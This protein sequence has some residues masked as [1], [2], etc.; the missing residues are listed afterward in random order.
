MSQP[1]IET[2]L[3]HRTQG[4]IVAGGSAEVT[5]E[6]EA[7]PGSA[8][9]PRDNILDTIEGLFSNEVGIV[10][11]EGSDGIGKTTILRQ[12]RDRHPSHTFAVFLSAGS[13]WA[14]D[15]N[16]LRDE[17]CD[18]MARVV[19][20]S[21]RPD[22][23]SPI[24][25][26][27]SR[28]MYAVGRVARASGE[29]LYFILDGLE[30]IPAE[31]RGTRDELF[32]LMPFLMP[33]IRC[34][35]T[36]PSDDLPFTE[37]ARRRLK[38]LQIS[39]VTREEAEHFLGGLGLTPDVVRVICTETRG[40]PGWLASVRRLLTQGLSASTVLAELHQKSPDLF[41][42]EWQTV[43]SDNRRRLLLALL[44]RDSRPYS[45]ERLAQIAGV[46]VAAVRAH[47]GSLRFLVWDS[48]DHG[49]ETVRYL[50]ESFRRAADAELAAHRA[51]VDELI[52]AFLQREPE[53]E[54][55]LAQL[56]SFFS[57]TDR[58][59]EL[60]A[61][62]SPDR[63]LAL[64]RKSPSIAHVQQQTELGAAAARKLGRRGDIVRF[65]LQQ[66]TI[67]EIANS[68]L[69]TSEVR[70][71]TA[72]HDTD[73][74]LAIAERA[75][76]VADRFKLLVAVAR[77]RREVGLPED[78]TLRERILAVYGEL[79]PTSL[80]DQ[81][82]E[83]AAD[84]FH[85]FP[86]LAIELVSR[87]AGSVTSENAL[88][89]AFT[90]LA[91]QAQ[92]EERDDGR[93]KVRELRDRIGTPVAKRL[94]T[95]AIM[96]LGRL[97][98]AEA[99]AEAGRLD[100]TADQLYVLRH[101]MLANATRADAVDVLDHALQLALQATAY[102]SN[103]QV[104]RELATCLPHVPTE[105]MAHFYLA[106]FDAHRTALERLGPTEEF[107]RL[108]LLLARARWR[109]DRI[110][111][112]DRYLDV[113]NAIASVTDLA[114]R[115][116]CGARLI[117][118]LRQVDPDRTLDEGDQLHAL[119][120]QEFD[121]GLEK[122][123][124]S[125]ADHYEATKPVIEAL[126]VAC[127]DLGAR[128]ARRLNTQPRRDRAHE[129]LV[130]AG[131]SNA[132]STATADDVRQALA[133]IVD[134]NVR[135]AAKFS[136]LSNIARRAGWGGVQ[137]EALTSDVLGVG[138]LAA[139]ARLAAEFLGLLGDNGDADVRDQLRGGVRAAWDA[140]DRDWQK[141]DVGYDVIALVAKR[142]PSFARELGAEIN[143][144][145]AQLTLFDAET[146]V[147]ANLGLRLASRAYAGLVAR[148]VSSPRD[149]PRLRA[150]IERVGSLT[151]Q[152]GLWADTALRLC[153]HG[154]QAEAEA[155]LRD[156]LLP[157]VTASQQADPELRRQLLILV[158]PAV[159][160]AARGAFEGLLNELPDTDRDEALDAVTDALL[161][162]VPPGEP[163]KHVWGA[164]FA[165]TFPRIQEIV[166]LMKSIDSDAQIFWHMIGIVDSMTSAR[167]RDE[168]KG[169]QRTEVARLL[170][171]IAA[172]KF[173]NRR[174]I[175]HQGYV[176]AAEATILRLCDVTEV[177]RRLPALAEQ[178]RGIPNISDRAFVLGYVA[179]AARDSRPR[180]EYLEEAVAIAEQLPILLERID[181]LTSLSDMMAVSD[182]ARSRELL[183]RAFT[184]TAQ[185][186]GETIAERRRAIVDEMHRLDS[187]TAASLASVMDDEPAKRRIEERL[188]LH[189]LKEALAAP[190]TIDEVP[191]PKDVFDYSSAAWMQLGELNAGRTPPLPP[192]RTLEWIQYA[193]IQ[194]VGHGY[195]IFAWAIENAVRHQ[196]PETRQFL[197]PLFEA[198]LA[199][200]ELALRAATRPDV[201]PVQLALRESPTEADSVANILVRDGERQKGLSVIRDWLQE[202]RPTELWIA[203]PYFVPSG[204]EALL[205]VQEASPECKIRVLTGKQAH[206]HVAAPYEDTYRDEWTR[207]SSLAP[208]DTTIVL[209]G[210]TVSGKSPVHDRWWLSSAG[211]LK[212]GTS[213]S[214]IGGRWSEIQRIP[215]DVAADRL[216]ALQP[217][218]LTTMRQFEGEPLR[219][220]TI[221]L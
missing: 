165:V 117:A 33:G 211:G 58:L 45:A 118:S 119:A 29:P 191:K 201:A 50:S 121:D 38:T 34:L 126:A 122:L 19:P 3:A 168:F 177:R 137:P 105:Q 195:P 102:S 135:E 167:L 215:A 190:R 146:A 110:A 156:Q 157:L 217:F 104:Y 207:L 99:I 11:L 140:L 208:P 174:F 175:T 188:A 150:A 116:A 199:G 37:P 123:L 184:L 213:T 173:P 216:Q 166:T 154:K 56:P 144:L 142:F 72:L 93:Q 51:Q 94:S 187:R 48:A 9:I 28:L 205:L 134:G 77:T 42:L 108:Q 90:R 4:I 98:A 218:F 197:V 82:A 17:F 52:I 133:E 96:L 180:R 183:Q 71:L 69:A 139:R 53:G 164:G 115:V 136:W 125:T 132:R 172:E 12:L 182:A 124:A 57:S 13:R 63:V 86:D 43:G 178:A 128:V 60:V 155:V 14:Y 79:D 46:D 220:S 196:G 202:V 181:R 74:A 221:E 185:G 47:L 161:Q 209:A 109:F 2:A 179:Q 54:E 16:I 111:G 21:Q 84:L 147:A 35:V 25:R 22:A 40:V 10:V 76:R 7:A 107:I 203:D 158:L 92:P 66:S 64:Y 138:E 61:Y 70:A 59:A 153:A 189:K 163:Y 89:W 214:G 95:E 131:S 148:G 32:R 36:G 67:A 160:R 87:S 198:C 120:E 113:Y 18:Q 65:S 5:R 83:V 75:V 159:Y 80:G 68:M 41:R 145:K 27:F 206:R 55:A 1:S 200:A 186:K 204:L 49:G 152:A 31:D 171:E 6:A 26:R 97:S 30:E 176:V 169:A 81:A 91:I 8:E 194:P 149:L 101:W 192:S 210:T 114:S 129:L 212:L 103:A 162:N 151:E 78:P 39:T 62:L 141:L 170:R 127:F 85:T 130:D 88:D 143:T 15:P 24:D 106:K 100:Q 20:V 219:Y 23:E 193:A 73:E 112:R 44:A